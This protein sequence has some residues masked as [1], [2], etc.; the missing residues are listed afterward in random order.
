MAMNIV[1]VLVAFVLT[2]V[3]SFAD[4][5]GFITVPGDAGYSIVSVWTYLLPIVVGWLHVG[6]QPEAGHLH[7]ALDD[8]HHIAYVATASEPVLATQVTRAIENSTRHIDHVNADEKK[9]TPIFNYARVFVWSQNA[10]DIL[11]LYQHATAKADRR[12]TV[13]R[14]GE[15]LS[16]GHGAGTILDSNRIGNEEEVIQYCMD[17]P[18]VPASP[19]PRYS[20]PQSPTPLTRYSTFPPSPKPSAITYANVDAF[21]QRRVPTMLSKYDEEAPSSEVQTVPE[22]PVVF[23]TEVFQRV[24]IATILALFLQWSTT[25]API[26]IHLITPPKGFGCRAL[27]FIIYGAAATLAFGLLL[28]S[29]IFAHLARRQSVREERS[30]LKTLIGHIATLMR[31]LGKLIAISNG[32]GILIS[33]IMQFAGVYDNCFCSSTVFGGSPNGLVSFIDADVRGSQVYK[34]WI[35]GVTVAFGAS[36]LYAFAIYVA[37]PMG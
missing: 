23:A 13:R 5:S 29:S 25:G 30:G 9:T 1:W 36:G 18:E 8:A 3:D 12:I 35:G 20:L 28:F 17:E 7:D 22:K 33:C 34:Y 14:G 26:L 37:T 15:W 19:N 6:S 21:A 11:R 16:N 24:I 4:F 27:T 2:L 31:W 10:E 32:I